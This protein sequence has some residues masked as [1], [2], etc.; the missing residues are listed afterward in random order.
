MNTVFNKQVVYKITTFFIFVGALFFISKLSLIFLP[1]IGVEKSVESRVEIPYVNLKLGEIFNVKNQPPPVVVEE[2]KVE[3][4]ELTNIELKAL[5]ANQKGEGWIVIVDK[6]SQKSEVLKNNQTFKGYTLVEITKESAIFENSG[7]KY[8]VNIIKPNLQ[9][10]KTSEVVQK[11]PPIKSSQEPTIRAVPQREI[12]KYRANFDEIWRNIAIKE[13]VENGEITGFKIN[14]IKE[15]SIFAQ[16]GF[17]VGDV[18][19]AV[20]NKELKSYADAFNI[21]NNIHIHKSLKFTIERENAIRELEY[22]V[23]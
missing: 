3:I 13:R 4:Y 6:A 12:A 1:Q 20:N 9:E 18:I 14:W 23:Y 11:P 22:E 7:K 5:F 10:L 19:K 21:Y 2:P 15:D 17:L 16:L 8:S